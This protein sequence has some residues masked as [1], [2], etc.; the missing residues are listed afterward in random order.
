MNPSALQG[1]GRFRSAM[2]AASTMSGPICSCTRFAS[3]SRERDVLDS[4]CSVYHENS[5]QH[6]ACAKDMQSLMESKVAD[7]AE[8]TF[9]ISKL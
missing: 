5:L 1:P 2:I 6:Q 3:L 8:I 7:A 4:K 9:Y